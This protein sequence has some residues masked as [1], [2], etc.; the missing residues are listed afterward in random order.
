MSGTPSKWIFTAPAA[1][2]RK[3]V[4]KW[5]SV[6]CVK[7]GTTSTV[8]AFLTMS[9]KIKQRSPGSVN[10]V[11]Q[12]E[13]PPHIY[14]GVATLIPSSLSTLTCILCLAVFSLHICMCLHLSLCLSVFLLITISLEWCSLKVIIPKY[15]GE[16][17]AWQLHIPLSLPP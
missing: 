6:M 14:L 13:T 4:I 5:L 2:L 1:C 8:W 15:F 7:P 9:L 10:H 11:P 12:C 3:K 17:C 16:R